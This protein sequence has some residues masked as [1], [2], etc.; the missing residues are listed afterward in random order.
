MNVN[1]RMRLMLI[2]VLQVVLTSLVTY[3]F[4]TKEYR[5]LSSESLITLEKFLIDQKKQELKNYTALAK[6]SV[7]HLYSQSIP[8]NT[9]IKSVVA[10][11][12]DGLLYNGDDGYFFVYDGNGTNISH[13]K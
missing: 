9:A 2:A 11:I 6:S 5:D 8:D 3:Y 1:F 10:Q 7:N 4:V 13:P 12:F